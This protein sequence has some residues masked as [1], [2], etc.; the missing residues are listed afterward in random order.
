MLLER[1]LGDNCFKKFHLGR[2]IVR[3]MV[4]NLVL[5][6]CVSGAVNTDFECISDDKTPQIK[7]LNMV[8]TILMHK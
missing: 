3:Y 6:Q 8:I 4:G 1:E 2:Y 7:I 5:R